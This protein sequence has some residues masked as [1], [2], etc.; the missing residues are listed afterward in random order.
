[1]SQLFNLLLL[2]RKTF[3]KCIL[4]LLL[5]PQIDRIMS[6]DYDLQQEK[7]D[8]KRNFRQVHNKL[9]KLYSVLWIVKQFGMKAL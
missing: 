4:I 3:G 9:Q 7:L 2:H 6:Y 1:M 8:V 5:F